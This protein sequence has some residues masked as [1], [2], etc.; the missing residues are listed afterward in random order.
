LFALAGI[1][2]YVSLHSRT[3]FVRN[4]FLSLSI[5]ASW[6]TYAGSLSL[7][8]CAANL[9][10]TTGAFAHTNKGMRLCLIGGSSVWLVHNV[11]AWTP[12]GVFME[13]LFLSSGLIGYFRQFVRSARQDA[14]MDS[15]MATEE[16]RPRSAPR[17]RTVQK[18]ARQ[19]VGDGPAC[20]SSD[21][22]RIDPA[23][24]PG[25]R[26]SEKGAERN[27]GNLPGGICPDIVSL[28][29]TTSIPSGGGNPCDETKTFE[30][31]RSTA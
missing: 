17:P 6:W 2:L 26:G 29:G 18:R 25:R 7:I 28:P 8:G 3:D 24:T 10:M 9:I 23:Y 14:L 30:P 1:R 22:D 13:L 27:V 31:R 4:V 19:V 11:L 15:H 12:V 20:G 5:L 21:V 16:H